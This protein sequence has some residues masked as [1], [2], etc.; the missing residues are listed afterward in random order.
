MVYGE[1]GK[2]PMEI[3]IKTR[4]ITY[5]SKLING[6]DKKYAK[7]LYYLGFK[8][9]QENRGNI[10]WFENIKSI[11]NHTGLSNIW[12]EQTTHSTKWLKAKIKLTLTDQFKQNWQSTVQSSPNALNYCMYKDELKLEDYFNVL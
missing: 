10:A 2:Y 7:L 4:M 9:Q 1:L 6:K 8:L 5:W 3:Q 12:L 11:L